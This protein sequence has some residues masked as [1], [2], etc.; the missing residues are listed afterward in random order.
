M[1]LAIGALVLVFPKSDLLTLLRGETDQ[2]NR[3]LTTAYLRNII[4]TEP[5]DLSLRLLLVEKLLAGGELKEARQILD[6]AQPLT[7][8]TAAGLVDW[9]R[10]DLAWWQ[11]QLGQAIDGGKDADIR[12]AA[13]ELLARLKRSAES[14]NN[15]AQVFTSISAA[16][17]L[18]AMLGTSQP[19]LTQ[20]IQSMQD[21]LLARLVNLPS[22]STQDLASGATMALFTMR[23]RSGPDSPR[24]SASGSATSWR[25][26][27]CLTL[28]RTTRPACAL[29]PGSSRASSS[30]S[31]SRNGPATTGC[32]I[33]HFSGFARTRAIRK[34]S[35]RCR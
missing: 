10:W 32:A 19:A 33:R 23:A 1:V 5:K 35:R 20:Q 7:R 15:A 2:G 8:A 17:V 31:P 27:S 30:R 14:V 12:Q 29:P 22:A 3:D 21:L 18:A 28:R 25:K 34:C 16:N 26:T 13:T 6:D 9:N 4:R 11:A 24:S